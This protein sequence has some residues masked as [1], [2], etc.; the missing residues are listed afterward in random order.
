MAVMSNLASNLLVV[1]RFFMRNT[2]KYSLQL[3]PI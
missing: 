2:Y 3:F 1:K